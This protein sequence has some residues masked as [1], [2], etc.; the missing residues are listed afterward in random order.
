MS[1]TFSQGLL[2]AGLGMGLV[3]AMILALWG[4]MVLLVRLTN[5]KKKEILPVDGEAA[6][7]ADILADSLQGKQKLAAATAVAC[8]LKLEQAKRLPLNA[9][10]SMPSQWLINGRLQQML[11]HA[12][13]G[14]R[15]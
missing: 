2:I 5:P 1:E 3:F 12:N 8:A 4:I 9:K 10:S 7:E 13:R 11:I 6:G 14:R 15:S